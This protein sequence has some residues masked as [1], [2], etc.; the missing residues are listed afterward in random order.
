M[1]GQMAGPMELQAQACSGGPLERGTRELNSVSHSR[2]WG[3]AAQFSKA[4]PDLRT[5]RLKSPL[6]R[7]FPVN[8]SQVLFNKL[9]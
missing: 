4:G 9:L 5:C 1:T 7:P 8:P 3:P 6:T 2:N